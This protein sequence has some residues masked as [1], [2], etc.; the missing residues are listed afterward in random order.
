MYYRP[1]AWKLPRLPRNAAEMTFTLLAAENASAMAT[2][3]SGSASSAGQS[4]PGATLET[5]N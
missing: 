4:T 1:P 5:A 3:M 2:S